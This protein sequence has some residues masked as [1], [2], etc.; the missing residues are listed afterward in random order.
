M[1]AGYAAPGVT[2]T[3]HPGNTIFAGQSDTLVAT[4]TGSGASTATYQW[5]VNSVPVGGATTNKYISSTLVNMDIVTCKVANSDVC[6]R[7]TLGS[8]TI[9]VNNL[10]V[11]MVNG[12]ATYV[13][14]FPNPNKGV[15]VI[16]GAL[17]TSSEEVVVEVTNTIGQTVYKSAFTTPGGII[18]QQIS[19]ANL[20]PG[21]YLVSMH[22]NSGN[23]VF[24]F[25]V[26]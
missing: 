12:D 25:I 23:K 24:H 9:H 4:A 26:E 7:S 3:A 11:D 20:V 18:N 15:F 2:V 10:D 21:M 8:A 17:G 22:S 6:A 13:N 14:I 1:I 19:I 16:K 5:Y